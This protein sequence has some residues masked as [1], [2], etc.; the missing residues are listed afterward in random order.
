M[1]RG[2]IIFQQGSDLVDFRTTFA[3][4]IM[5]YARWVHD[6]FRHVLVDACDEYLETND[7]NSD[8]TRSK[9]ISRISKEITSIAKTNN[10]SLPDELEKVHKL[11]SHFRMS[12]TYSGHIVRV[13]ASGWETPRTDTRRKRGLRNQRWTLVAT[14]H[15]AGAGRP[16]PY[17]ST[18]LQTA[19]PKSRKIYPRAMKRTLASMV[20]P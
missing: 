8:K 14:L 3:N 13:C 20:Q 5:V 7:R 1:D 9:L 17:A 15:R 18:S 2:E 6:S 4:S 12:E 19:F 11:C 16:S 10:E